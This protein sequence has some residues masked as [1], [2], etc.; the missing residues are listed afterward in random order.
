MSKK[1]KKE[2]KVR[3]KED[4]IFSALCSSNIEK[5]LSY[6]DELTLEELEASYKG[7]HRY[8]G[9]DCDM[10]VSF[11]SV[12]IDNSHNPKMTP[13]IEK[14]VDRG[15]DVNNLAEGQT[16]S[17]ITKLLFTNNL[18]AAETLITKGGAL[19][20]LKRTDPKANEPDEY[21]IAEDGKSYRINKPVK[22]C[23]SALEYIETAKKFDFINNPDKE[24]IILE[25]LR[26]ETDT[27]SLSNH[28]R[29]ASKILV[30]KEEEIT[31][32]K[33]YN[34]IVDAARNGQTTDSKPVL[35]KRADDSFIPKD[36]KKPAMR[37][38]SQ[39]LA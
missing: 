26:G 31:R 12:A 24:D 36:Q 21:I 34:L 8:N 6:A 35:R 27:S 16:Y 23:Q 1:E 18:E 11:L 15:V 20:D 10:D 32:T 28:Y 38:T 37:V 14:L 9:V 4:K 17:N 5:M 25:R 2:K 30:T 7:R 22:T 39:N 19:V 29:Y 3:T 33:L 13:I